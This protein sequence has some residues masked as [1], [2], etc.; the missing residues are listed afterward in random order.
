M[1]YGVLA[2]GEQIAKSRTCAVV[3]RAL[4]SQYEPLNMLCCNAF[5]ACDRQRARFVLKVTTGNLV[6]QL[7]E[8]LTGQFL[9][10]R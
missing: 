3:L 6:A 7:Y 9:T 5:C 2:S 1:I 8:I 10:G 4:G